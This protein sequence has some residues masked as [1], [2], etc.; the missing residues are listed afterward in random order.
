[1][2][3]PSQTS[4]TTLD[5]R[6]GALVEAEYK[7]L[8]DHYFHEDT[9]LLRTVALFATLNGAILAAFGSTIIPPT[10]NLVHALLPALG[11]LT[12][13]LWAVCLYRVHFVRT[14]VE[15]R[16][17]ELEKA[18]NELWRST[19]N[20]PPFDLLRIRA[21]RRK[22][23]FI[24]RWP[25]SKIMLSFPTAFAV[26]WFLLALNLILGSPPNPPPPAP[27]NSVVPK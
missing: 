26:I 4:P 11:M 13:A 15:E 27:P 6:D 23:N 18:I 21:G 10:Q 22:G 19:K 8:S 2:N 3:E 5:W 20:T 1:M 7:L 12:T 24:Q 9:Y 16:H 25:V 17:L 14:Q